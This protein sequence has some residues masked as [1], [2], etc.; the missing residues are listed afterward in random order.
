MSEETDYRNTYGAQVPP[1]PPRRTTTES[2]YELTFYPGFASRCSLRSSA[3]ELVLY[4]QHEPYVLPPGEVRPAAEHEI[5]LR[6]GPSQQ[7]VRLH[8]NDP[9][10]RIARIIVEVYADE[11]PLGSSHALQ[12][13]VEAL[14]VENRAMLCPPMCL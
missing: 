10:R 7:D 12:V 8:I 3:G 2:G 13:P 6:G 9:R 4:Q 14:I 1:D 11:L 5:H